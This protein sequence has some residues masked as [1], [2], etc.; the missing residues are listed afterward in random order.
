M[1]RS[2][3]SG[4]NL[5]FYFSSKFKN[6]FLHNQSIIRS[7]MAPPGVHKE[8]FLNKRNLF[9]FNI[10]LDQK[11]CPLLKYNFIYYRN[12]LKIQDSF[13][14]KIKYTS[15]FLRNFTN[16]YKYR[17]YSVLKKESGL[18]VVGPD[19]YVVQ[20]GL[21]ESAETNQIH[22]L[23]LISVKIRQTKTPKLKMQKSN[24]QLVI[25]AFGF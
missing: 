15:R 20:C 24:C 22:A 13:Q 11:L 19:V 9:H 12:L 23:A 18:G 4:E 2:K 5:R 21:V 10:K 3:G 6:N 14:F 8:N 25:D 1:E 17:K 16:M 7:V